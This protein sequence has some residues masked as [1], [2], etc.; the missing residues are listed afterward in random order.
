MHVPDEY[1]GNVKYKV[2]VFIPREGNEEFIAKLDKAAKKVYD[3][4]E[5][6]ATGKLKAAFKQ[7]SIKLKP[8][9]T[10]VYDDDGEDTGVVEL[11]A[12]SNADHRPAVFDSGDARNGIKPKRIPD[13]RVFKDDIINTSV[14]ASTYFSDGLGCAGVSFLLQAV[15]IVEKNANFKTNQEQGD[16][17]EFEAA[18]G[19]FIAEEGDCSGE[20]GCCDDDEEAAADGDF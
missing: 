13:G 15:Q 5:A 12:A 20:P 18:D 8:G 9:Y 1:K 3:E 10:V 6:E 14:L 16:D 2:S 11:R 4:A 19:G 7:G 17:E